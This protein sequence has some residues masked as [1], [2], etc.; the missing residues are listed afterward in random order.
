ML[1]M[2]VSH[3]C[4][5][6]IVPHLVTV[7]HKA[8]YTLEISNMK[9]TTFVHRL[10]CWFTQLLQSTCSEH[11]LPPPNLVML[12]ESVQLDEFSGFPKH[13]KKAKFCLS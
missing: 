7:T 12:Q 6:A 2:F 4:K 13:P 11:P 8:R 1:Q 9:V 3:T 5:D 10:L